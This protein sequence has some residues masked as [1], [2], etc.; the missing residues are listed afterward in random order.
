MKIHQF[1]TFL[2]FYKVDNNSKMKILKVN[3]FFNKSISNI[4]KF[5]IFHQKMISNQFNNYLKIYK[6]FTLF[7][8]IK[9]NNNYNKTKKIKKFTKNNNIKMNNK[10]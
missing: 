6:I 8:N 9:Q 2:S 5:S 3:F 1:I 10:T 7:L 4:L